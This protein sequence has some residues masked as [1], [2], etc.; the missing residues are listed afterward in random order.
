MVVA[1]GQSGSKPVFGSDTSIRFSP[2]EIE[3]A[4]VSLLA[5]IPFC[6]RRHPANPGSATPF[7]SKAGYSEQAAAQ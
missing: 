4:F 3:R 5:S 1:D 6:S 2:L 7:D